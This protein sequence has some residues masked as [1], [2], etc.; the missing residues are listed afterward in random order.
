M[1]KTQRIRKQL[2]SI[3]RALRSSRIDHDYTKLQERKEMLTERLEGIK[4][5][6]H[7]RRENDS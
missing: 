3:N 5:H 1:N 4:N 7:S 6:F 2:N